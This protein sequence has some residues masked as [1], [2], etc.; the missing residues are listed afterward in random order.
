MNAGDRHLPEQGCDRDRVEGAEDRQSVPP[1]AEESHDLGSDEP[2]FLDAE[3][4]SECGEDQHDAGEVEGEQG[5]RI[6][7]DAGGLL[8]SEGRVDDLDRVQHVGDDCN[9][10]EKHDVEQ[11]HRFRLDRQ[12]GHVGRVDQPGRD[13]DEER[14]S[15][16]E[17]VAVDLVLGHR[18]ADE[19]RE[20]S[21]R[22][23]ES[24]DE[25]GEGLDPGTR[26][27]ARF[28]VRGPGGACTILV[29]RQGSPTTSE[30]DLCLSVARWDGPETA[31]TDPGQDRERPERDHLARSAVGLERERGRT[32][33]RML[34]VPARA[35][36]ARV[37]LDRVEVPPPVGPSL[38]P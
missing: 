21:D 7:A 11:R 16:G 20:R 26:S 37:R 17:D 13:Q 30:L 35:G 27:A 33:V 23:R 4:V 19:E 3:D 38:L 25:V 14:E 6:V 31:S 5:G 22:E 28:S 34:R 36:R 12:H 8:R 32:L 18:R 10:E 29:G 24:E 9:Q 2:F 1:I 15:E